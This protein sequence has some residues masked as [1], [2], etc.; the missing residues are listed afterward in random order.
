ME[1]LFF[2][3]IGSVFETSELQ[4]E[5]FNDAFLGAGLDWHW[6]RETYR[7]LLTTSGGRDRVAAEGRRRG[8]EVDARAIHADKTARFQAI[9]AERGVAPRPGVVES[10]DMARGLGMAV[11][12]I[13]TTAEGSLRA[14]LGASDPDLGA[15]DVVTSAEDGH[16]GKP[17]PAVYL[18]V[19]DRLGVPASG[20]V[21]VED[22][23]AGIESAAAAGLH[24]VAYLGENTTLH[25]VGAAQVVASGSVLP[26]VRAL[27]APAGEGA[28]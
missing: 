17:D 19:L 12:L 18:A 10:L 20:A 27:L 25:P 7:R 8:V 6:D 1:A 24:V 22:N 2:G 11:G 28:A 21:A 15:L 14:A 23:R 4:R 3:S 5:A 26:A 13:S 16:P 9:M